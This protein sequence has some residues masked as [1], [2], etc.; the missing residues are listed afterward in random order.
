MKPFISAFEAVTKLARLRNSEMVLVRSAFHFSSDNTC[1]LEQF[2]VNQKKKRNFPWKTAAQFHTKARPSATRVSTLFISLKLSKQT[3]ELEIP[4]RKLSSN[5]K[6]TKTFFS[7]PR[8]YDLSQLLWQIIY[9]NAFMFHKIQQ[10]SRVISWSLITTL[11]L[12]AEYISSLWYRSMCSPLWTPHSRSSHESM[13]EKT[14]PTGMTI[15]SMNP[16][17]DL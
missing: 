3:S 5:F 4:F 14:L 17:W 11:T 2:R 9:H 10:L 16:P 15:W 6:S 8:V 13:N 1:H 12:P 7:S